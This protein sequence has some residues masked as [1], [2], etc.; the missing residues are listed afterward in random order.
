MKTLTKNFLL[1]ELRSKTISLIDRLRNITHLYESEHKLASDNQKFW[2]KDYSNPI[3]AQE[4]H[5]KNNGKFEDQQRWLNLGKEHFDLLSNYSSVIDFQLPV[6]QIVEWGCGGGA[7]AVH[8]APLTEKFI[9]I[10]ITSESLAE[11]NKQ[12]LELGYN[13]FQPILIDATTPELVLN[14][15][16]SE[17]DLF[18]C[19]YVFE[20]FP[21]PDYGL[22]VLNLANKMLKNDGIAFIQIRYNDGRRKGMKSKRWG[23]KFHPY[24]MTTYSLEEFWKNSKEYGFEPLGI[25]LKPE[26]PLVVDHS[27][28]YFFLK[29]KFVN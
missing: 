22:T 8:F 12:I 28:A 26:Q 9:G 21:S 17:I 13:N 11:C 7:N 16:I 20:Q 2:N 15:K 29:K 3:V 23:Y 14:H 6:K 10:D 19:V 1:K 24:R 18:I 5:W 4:A 27:Y 25:Y